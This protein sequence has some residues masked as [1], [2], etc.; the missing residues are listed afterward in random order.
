[1]PQPPRGEAVWNPLYAL[2]ETLR[3]DGVAAET[4]QRLQ[5]DRFTARPGDTVLLYG[6]VAG[7]SDPAVVGRLLDWV[8]TG[9]HL[10]LRTP[11]P[12]PADDDDGEAPAP[13]AL[14]RALGV[15]ALHPSECAALQVKGRKNTWSC[16]RAGGSPCAMAPL[17]AGRGAMP[18][19]V[20]CSPASATARARSTSSP[21][22]TSSTTTHSAKPPTGPRPATAR[23]QLR[24]R[25]RAPWST[26]PRPSRC[27][28]GWPATAG[29]CGCR[30]RCCWPVGCGGMGS[31]SARGC[32]RLP[33]RAA[34]CTNTCVPAAPCCCAT[35][36]RHCST[37]RCARRLWRGCA[38]ATRPPPRCRARRACTRWPNACSTRTPP[39]ATR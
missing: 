7:L 25:H 16:A 10:L 34:R 36:S 22:S 21:T 39:S 1:M 24:A 14:M 37:T 38:G 17:R 3:A 13:P 18:T 20:T 33:A 9:G 32:R 35:G 5:P 29:R 31:A 26:T 2:R 28:G 11:P 12:D 19:T 6:D 8:A 15:D 30:W 23:A 27:G 4:R